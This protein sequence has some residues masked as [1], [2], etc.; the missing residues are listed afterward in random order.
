MK[1]MLL[2]VAIA[3]GVAG[4]AAAAVQ[5][6]GVISG[7][8]VT[9]KTLV[10]CD[11]RSIDVTHPA[12][13]AT[14]EVVRETARNV[15]PQDLRLL[16]RDSNGKVLRFY[17]AWGQVKLPHATKIATYEQVGSTSQIRQTGE[18]RLVRR[19]QEIVGQ[20]VVNEAGMQSGLPEL[21]LRNCRMPVRP[22]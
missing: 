20:L 14:L 8:P 6:G 10:K 16:T 7:Q 21:L 15:D 1:T 11:A 13:E 9:F 17:R 3:L 19:G 4:P 22:L 12:P 18:L 2:S 5:S